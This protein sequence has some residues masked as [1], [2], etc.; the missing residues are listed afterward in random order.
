MALA[1]LMNWKRTAAPIEA[2]PFISSQNV[3]SSVPVM[4]QS[5]RRTGLCNEAVKPFTSYHVHVLTD[6]RNGY[7]LLR[8]IAV[9]VS[10]TAHS[11]G[12]RNM[13]V[14]S[15][16][17]H[18]RSE[19]AGWIM[20]GAVVAVMAGL[21]YFSSGRSQAMASRARSARCGPLPVALILRRSQHANESRQPLHG[22]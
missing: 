14:P 7:G 19:Q 3:S 18:H 6:T 20:A 4:L 15:Y 21:V 16:N 1:R 9:K 12:E 5:Y 8:F 17:N 22:R 11:F 10:S 13:L 2:P